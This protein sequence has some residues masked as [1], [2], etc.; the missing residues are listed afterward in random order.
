MGA[1]NCM[2]RRAACLVTMLLATSALAQ[3]TFKGAEVTGAGTATC[4]EATLP[5]GC[6]YLPVSG[7]GAVTFRL[8]GTWAGTV[9]VEGSPDGDAAD[10]WVALD[11]HTLAT[12]AWTMAAST[13]AIGTYA[14]AATG[15]RTLRLRASVYTSGTIVVD[16]W[17]HSDPWSVV[18]SRA[19][20]GSLQVS[21][22][23][24]ASSLG[25]A[26]D[27]VHGTG[28]VGIMSLGVRN[29]SFATALSGTDGDYTPVGVDAQGRVGIAA[30]ANVIGQVS[31]NQTTP[32]TTN[33]VQITDGAGAVNVIVD[34]SALPSGASTAA[35][36]GAG[37][38]AALVGG[39]LDV[40]VGAAL[41][42]G[43]NNFG[44]VDVEIV[45]A[46][47]TVDTALTVQAADFDIEA[48][49]ANLRLMSFTVRESAAV[50]AAAPVI[51]RHGVLA[52]AVCSAGGVFAF[53]ELAPN[54]SVQMDFGPR[55]LAAASG[56]CADVVAGTVDAGITTVTEGAP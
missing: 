48:A 37:L 5:R 51:L 56:V 46:A 50:A 36:Q 54:E 38:P 29:D 2:M 34:S 33:L 15:M 3:D 13:T 18:Y 17:T 14:V 25:K 30:G 19:A 41:P 52:A 45:G 31:I 9:V 22:G 6:V 47:Q 42:A 43:T 53:V 1:E 24:G 26:E 27:A 44:D 21:T 23:V 8:S 40:N 20:D 35:L 28:D 39:R 16:S 11:I 12:G 4:I 49:T 32:G 7:A 55:G 10:V